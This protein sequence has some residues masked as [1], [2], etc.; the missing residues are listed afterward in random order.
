M[1]RKKDFGS[2][3]SEGNRALVLN[4]EVNM[5]FDPQ[6]LRC[7]IVIPAGQILAAR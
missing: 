4:A 3:V 7:R 6:G 5:V 1:I 2:M